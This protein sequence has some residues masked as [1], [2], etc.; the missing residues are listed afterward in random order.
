MSTTVKILFCLNVCIS[1]CLDKGEVWL[2]KME[3]HVGYTPFSSFILFQ[4]GAAIWR[5]QE[6][7]P[8]ASPI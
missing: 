3:L 6:F 1:L 8:R 5:R 7:V 2:L 4:K